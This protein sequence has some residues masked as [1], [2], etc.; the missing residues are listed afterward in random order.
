[1]GKK[2]Q[3]SI[4]LI[5]LVS[6]ALVLLSGFIIVEFIQTRDVMAAKRNLGAED[7]AN[8]L[9]TEISLA[10]RIDPVYTRTFDLPNDISGEEYSIVIGENEISIEVDVIGKESSHPKLIPWRIETV[11][12]I[13]TSASGSV[14]IPK[15][16]KRITINKPGTP[17]GD[18]ISISSEVVT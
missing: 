1:M 10:G 4:E 8:K 9:K 18:T 15:E 7:I 13:S 16:K 5:I 17:R 14:T 6:I 2:G 12:S 11:D 3:A